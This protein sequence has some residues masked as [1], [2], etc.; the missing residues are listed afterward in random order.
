[1]GDFGNGW[2]LALGSP[3]LEVNPAHDVTL[4]L[5]DGR[6]VSQT[7][8]GST[9]NYLWDELSPYGDVVLETDASSGAIQA[10]YT[11]DGQ[12]GGLGADARKQC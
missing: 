2:R 6:R 5:P 4:T 1:M 7:T 8:G 10:S 12:G 11:L 9:T 3:Q